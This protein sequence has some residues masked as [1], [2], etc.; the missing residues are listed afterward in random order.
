MNQINTVT[1]TKTK[2]KI[3][4]KDE[5]P[6]YPPM[7]PKKI[8]KTRKLI[9]KKL[10]LKKKVQKTDKVTETKKDDDVEWGLGVEHEFMLVIDDIDRASKA[11]NIIEKL[12]KNKL[13][14]EQK[15][16]L[17]KIY[18]RTN[19]QLLVPFVGLLDI[20]H[21]NIEDT[22]NHSLPMYEIKNMKYYNVNV[23][24][25]MKEIDDKMMEVQDKISK[26]LSDKIGDNV[27]V[28]PTPFGAHN[29]LYLK[30]KD[31]ANNYGSGGQG[32]F[33]C[34]TS[35]NLKLDTDYT[36]SYHF[37]V[38]LPH[39]K[40]DETDHIQSMHQKAVF[41]LQTIEPLL[42]SLY[43]SSD[44][45]INRKDNVPYMKGSFRAANNMY[46]SFGTT[47]AS[48]YKQERP[49][50]GFGFGNPVFNRVI[51]KQVYTPK[52]MDV[53]LYK[54]NVVKKLVKR[55]DSEEIPDYFMVHVDMN[56]LGADF[57]RK[58]G[59]K[60]F[61]FR[62]WDHFPQKYLPDILKIVYL[63]SCYATTI[64]SKHL[65]YSIEDQEWNNSM[66][67]ALLEGH[68]FKVHN[69]FVSFINKQFKL[70]LV[71]KKTSQQ[72]MEHMIDV[73]WNKV[74]SDK[75]AKKMYMLMVGDDKIKPKVS[76]VNKLSQEHANNIHN[77]PKSSSTSSLSKLSSKLSSKSSKTVQRKK[78]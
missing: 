59:I 23:E 53:S 38:T 60:G 10:F 31:I 70:K 54:N 61:E 43:G 62:I 57:R 51:N 11:V 45:N 12:I 25:V 2:H 65:Q 36:G 69:K 41:L 39:L 40:L 21:I 46:A 4:I 48:M 76:N 32:N 14:T 66:R 64:P 35:N 13:T 73:V 56:S 19:P 47:P 16:E 71:N 72:L 28:T 37:W 17:S 5:D 75:D 22:T 9:P 34:L 63:V 1:H 26:V 77:S 74:M 3:N 58:D 49:R 15:K 44:P 52:K 55:V 27:R 68:S 20:K 33:K 8:I 18:K 24:D 29:I 7:P 50:Y 6:N 67:D 30:C 42:C 78:K